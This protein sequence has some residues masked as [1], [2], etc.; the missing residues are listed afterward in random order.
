[1]SIS[2]GINYLLGFF[3]CDNQV[4]DMSQQLKAFFE[5]HAKVDALTGLHNRR[6]LDTVLERLVKRT[7]VNGQPL[8]LVMVDLDHF[9]SYND[10]LGHVAGDALLRSF[11]QILA[12]ENRA[13]NL[14]A[15]FG[16]DEFVAVLSDTTMDM[17][18]PYLRRVRERVATEPVMRDRQ[19]KVSLGV[20]EFDVATMKTA[21]DVIRVADA[22]LYARRTQRLNEPGAPSS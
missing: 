9:K 5:H 15:R 11:A 8:S 19:V 14:R 17:A 4:I 22:D 2:K 20:A 7:A 13:M 12:E 21:E 16:G 10:T 1:M 18:L 6:W 3:G